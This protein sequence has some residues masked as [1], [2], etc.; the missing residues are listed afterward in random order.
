MTSV[1]NLDWTTETPT[2]TSKSDI[3]QLM[4]RITKPPN[5][6]NSTKTTVGKPQIT[7]ITR[8][9]RI[10]G[11][12]NGRP[13]TG[14]MIGETQE[15]MVVLLNPRR[16]NYQSYHKLTLPKLTKNSTRFNLM[17][18]INIE[19]CTMLHQWKLI[20]S[21]QQVLKN[22]PNIFQIPVD[23]HTVMPEDTVR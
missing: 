16:R 7:G 20:N 23:F 12:I 19:L 1:K 13:E 17:L 11:M 9:G 6:R 15:E 14:T 10:P 4:A 5:G 3:Q 2:G 21:L 8:D 22:G 18:T